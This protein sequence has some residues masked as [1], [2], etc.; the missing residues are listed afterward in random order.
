[1]IIFQSNREKP[2]CSKRIIGNN[3]KPFILRIKLGEFQGLR[4]SFGAVKCPQQTGNTCY[5]KGVV[6]KLTQ[7]KSYRIIRGYTDN[8]LT[9][10]VNK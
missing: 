9:F 6:Y 3:L 2:D 7:T 5:S 4:R 1:M 10:Y 8:M